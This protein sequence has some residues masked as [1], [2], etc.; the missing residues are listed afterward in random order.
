MVSARV[1]IIIFKHKHFDFSTILYYQ[2]AVGLDP[3]PPVHPRAR[4]ALTFGFVAGNSPPREYT[5]E[6][7]Q[8][9]DIGFMKIF[10]STMPFNLSDLP[11]ESPFALPHSGGKSLNGGC[12]L[13]A[14]GLSL[15]GDIPRR[16]AFC[17][18]LSTVTCAF[19]STVVD[20]HYCG[21]I[22]M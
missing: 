5:L 11:Q 22:E 20:T 16:Y 14:S 8:N 7:G 2:P 13:V 1:I 19:V 21:G 18:H 15:A 3:D 6:E 17:M 10:L 12:P 4:G 9:F